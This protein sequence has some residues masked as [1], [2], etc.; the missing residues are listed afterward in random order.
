MMRSPSRG[1]RRRMAWLNSVTY[2]VEGT[3]PRQPLGPLRLRFDGDL[4][5]RTW[6]PCQT[7]GTRQGPYRPEGCVGP[8]K[9]AEPQEHGERLVLQIDR[10]A[11]T[12]QN[13]D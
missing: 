2:R 5:P 9:M 13:V 7:T 8:E 12:E 3:L 10:R 4:R 1:S 11:E 6:T